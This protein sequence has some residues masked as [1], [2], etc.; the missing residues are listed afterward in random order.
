MKKNK[1]QEIYL[2]IFIKLDDL[3]VP[4]VPQVAVFQ[5]HHSA[6]SPACLVASAGLRLNAATLLY[7]DF[8]LRLLLPCCSHGR[9]MR[10][11]V[12]C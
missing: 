2:D 3:G 8:R 11:D 10:D 7:T 4:F 6:R 9:A 5:T 12:F 1:M